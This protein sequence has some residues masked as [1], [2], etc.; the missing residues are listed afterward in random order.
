VFEILLWFTETNSWHDSFYRV[1]PKRKLAVTDDDSARD[2]NS[3]DTSNDSEVPTVTDILGTAIVH[4]NE[5]CG[6][7]LSAGTDTETPV[8]T[9]RSELSESCLIADGVMGGTII[10]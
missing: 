9:T 2:V 5:T 7:G 10:S 3:V 6:A 1:I 8:S 4:D